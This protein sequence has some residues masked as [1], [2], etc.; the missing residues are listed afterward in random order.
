MEHCSN[1]TQM[2][3]SLTMLHEYPFFGILYVVASA[4]F[5]I[6]ASL[7]NIIVV[8]SFWIASSL[9]R[10]SKILFIS[11]AA[12]D[13][14]V[15]LLAHPINSATIA[16]M[17]KLAMSSNATGDHQTMALLCSLVKTSLFFSIFFGGVS[18][19]TV[20]AISI[21]RYLV[22]L[23]HLRYAE[24]VTPRRVDFAVIT[25]WITSFLNALLQSLLHFNQVF[26][27]SCV[28]CALMVALFAY[29][30]IFRIA[31]HQQNRICGEG[32]Q[33]DQICK[34]TNFA[35]A[36]KMAMKTLYIY[37]ILI[38]CYIPSLFIFPT[39]AMSKSPT[40]FLTLS[41]YLAGFLIL[42]NSSLNPIVYCWKISE[43]RESVVHILKWISSRCIPLPH[44]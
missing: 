35:R 21:D 18:L 12:S 22:L 42:F 15:G 11:L 38:I 9:S 16:E 28:L 3:C 26:S 37:I 30:K 32:A 24:L 40:P 34:L 27:I 41:Y 5:S 8:Y 31:S 44:R 10:T 13:L 36:K 2:R 14:C 1:T 39:I 25:I 29:F 17:S 43:V 7:V 23:L 4:I 20:V 19:L 33:H 6:T